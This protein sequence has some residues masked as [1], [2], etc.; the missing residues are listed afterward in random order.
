MGTSSCIRFRIRRNVD[1]PQPDGP[2]S[3]VTFPGSMDSEIRSST[4]WEPNHALTL[5]A[6]KP[7]GGG[8]GGPALEAVVPSR[9]HQAV[10]RWW[11]WPRLRSPQSPRRLRPRRPARAEQPPRSEQPERCPSRRWRRARCRSQSFRC[12]PVARGCRRGRRGGCRR[13]R[14]ESSWSPSWRSSSFRS[15][16]SRSRGGGRSLADPTP[17][18]PSGRR[19]PWPGSGDA[20]PSVVSSDWATGPTTNRMYWASFCALAAVRPEVGT[21]R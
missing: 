17:S 6:S 2:I 15:G 21:T 8:R 5:V 13:R 18:P 14:G 16:R 19:P 3:A 9:A 10:A 7:D 12:S 20:D 11:S 1:F 4:L